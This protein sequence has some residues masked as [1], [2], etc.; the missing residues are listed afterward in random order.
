MLP[1]RATAMFTVL[2]ITLTVSNVALAANE[3]EQRIRHYKAQA[4]ETSGEALHLIG[5]KVSEIEDDVQRGEWEAVHER[6]YDLEASAET[7]RKDPAYKETAALD[8]FEESVQRIHY[9]SEHHKPDRV[10]KALHDLKKS[11][12]WLTGRNPR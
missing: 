2:A 6:S 11:A 1:V 7:L 12:Q 4:P 8:A 10:R 3:P 9:A 5:N